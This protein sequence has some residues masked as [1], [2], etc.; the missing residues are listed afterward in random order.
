VSDDLELHHY[1]LYRLGE[2]G[3]VGDELAEDLTDPHLVTVIEWAGI[4]EHDL[5]ADRLT[6]T[7]EVTGDEDRTLHLESGGPVS[8]RL[9]EA[10]R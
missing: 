9:V 10:M 8:S 7:I 5:P 4:I 3:V 1:D 2:T 6:I